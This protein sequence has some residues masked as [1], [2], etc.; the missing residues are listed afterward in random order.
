MDLCTKPTAFNIENVLKPPTLSQLSDSIYE[1]HQ[2]K[3]NV[4]ISDMDLSEC[5]L[6]PMEKTGTDNS[7]YESEITE[8]HCVKLQPMEWFH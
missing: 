2:I 5:D 3:M 4:T 7:I 6:E 1:F 8:N